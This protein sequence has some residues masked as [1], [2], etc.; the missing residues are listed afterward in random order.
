MSGSTPWREILVAQGIDPARV[1]RA[2]ATAAD[3]AAVAREVARD[4]TAPAHPGE[5]VPVLLAAR[6]D[7]T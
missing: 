4:P 6:E 5:L 2:E 1:A 3:L 7:G